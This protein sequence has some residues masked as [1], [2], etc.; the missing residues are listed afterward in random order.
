MTSE[1][2]WTGRP[3][4]MTAKS[5]DYVLRV[6][7]IRNYWYKW[8]VFKEDFEITKRTEYTLEE[9]KAAAIAAMKEHLKTR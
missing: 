5:G 4:D 6:E 3:D 1:I 8:S 7:N 2:I 9:A